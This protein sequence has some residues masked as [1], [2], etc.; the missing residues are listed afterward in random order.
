M[1][2]FRRATWLR[3]VRPLKEGGRAV[4]K[5]ESGGPLRF[6]RLSVAVQIGLSL[7]LLVGAGLFV[8]TLRNLKTL[9]LGF[10]PDHL[11]TFKIDPRLAG[12]SKEQTAPL[13]QRVLERLQ[14]LP[15]V[16]SVGATS[17][18]EINDSGNK[19][20]IT[21]A[22]YKEKPDEDMDVQ[23]SLVIPGYFSA[24]NVPLLAGRGITDADNTQTAKVVV[25]NEKFAKYFF[26]NPQQAIGHYFG[27]GG[28]NGTKLDIQIV[29]VVKDAKHRTVRGDMDRTVFQPYLQDPGPDAMTFYIRTTQPPQN[30]QGSIRAAMQ[31]LDS[32]L[33]L[34]SFLTMEEQIDSNLG[35][36]R[37]IALLATAFAGLAL[38]MAAVGLYGVLAY[39]TAQRTRE[40]GV[41]IALGASRGSVLKMVLM[42]VLWLAGAGIVV[43]LPL[44]LLLTWT[45]RSQLYGVSSS[46]SLDDRRR[47]SGAGGGCGFLCIASGAAGGEG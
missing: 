37:M 14:G 11:I 36:E 7:L 25:V 9:D 13:Y 23:Q 33:V 8:R 1:T 5:M 44:T 30:A 22:G 2:R 27:W 46:R 16:R 40:I 20:N 26:G 17:S 3:G 34:D 19:S 24:L 15:G 41:R 29:G 35:V 10:T 21:V 6:R 18:A 31:G 45:L 32:K 28:G 12:Y 43:F 39:S 38:F 4:A 42:E 47:N